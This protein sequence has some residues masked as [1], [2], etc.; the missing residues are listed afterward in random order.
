MANNSL[1]PQRRMRVPLAVVAALITALG[2]AV[3]LP[4]PATAAAEPRVSD[5]IVNEINQIASRFP[6]DFGG[7]VL[8]SGGTLTV[9]VVAGHH[10]FLDQLDK[11]GLS[12]FAVA[13]TVTHSFSELGDLTQRI[14]GDA[15][16][17]AAQ[18]IQ[19]VEW[20]PD[21][22]SNRVS[23]SLANPSAAAA[24]RLLQR[25]NDAWVDVSGDPAT[26]PSRLDRFSDTPPF[27]GGDRIFRP[28]SPS[29]LCT[30]GPAVHAVTSAATVYIL[31]AGHCAPSTG[32]TWY[33]NNTSKYTLG[34][35]SSVQFSNNGLD[36]EM[37]KANAG[38]DI[39]R[40]GSNFYHVV[41]ETAPAVG[42]SVCTDGSSSGEVCG[43]A[44]QKLNYCVT[45]SDGK[46]TCHL[47][48][49]YRAALNVCQGGDSGGP[50]YG[51]ISGSNAYVAGTIVGG[52]NSNQTCYWEMMSYIDSA[53]NVFPLS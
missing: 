24:A 41:G 31:T 2:V 46:T 32:T 20:G 11:A 38:P 51:S 45:F 39:W 49:G 47:D 13:K 6:E 27:W 16:L 9:S 12:K 19:L 21:I 52:T 43:V 17:L 8:G 53:F 30:S 26:R 50:V 22:T 1:I 35:V 7:D 33:T 3:A 37:I 28:K 36:V 40:N 23:I 29:V 25:Y 48:R 42:S 14:A 34:S 4:G 10:Q 18:G 5:K 15:P 44:V